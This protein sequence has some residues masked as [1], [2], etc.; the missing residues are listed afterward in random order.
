MYENKS[1][2]L[3]ARRDFRK[4]MFWHVLAALALVLVTLL[5]GVVGHMYFDNMEPGRALMAS[6]TL[7]SGLGLSIFPESAP[8]QV[9]A[10]LYG[11]FAGY[12]YIATSTIVIAP[13]LHRILHKFHLDE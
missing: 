1:E 5:A 11:F 2:P 13:L 9:F 10:S 7:S 4:R 3:V 8:G 12:V 6:V